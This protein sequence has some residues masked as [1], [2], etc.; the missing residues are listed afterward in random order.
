MEEFRRFR[1]TLAKCQEPL[2]QEALAGI[3][4]LV[5]EEM[6]AV[7]ERFAKQMLERDGAVDVQRLE[8]MVRDTEE[9]TLFLLEQDMRRLLGMESVC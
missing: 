2:P 6:P 8:L 5:K 7:R 9:I 4:K 1:D 3:Q